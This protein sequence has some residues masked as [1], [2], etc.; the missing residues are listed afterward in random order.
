MQIWFLEKGSGFIEEEITGF[1]DRDGICHSAGDV[2]TSAFHLVI[3][4]NSSQ[5]S[6][7][8]VGS[9]GLHRDFSR[10]TQSDESGGVVELIKSVRSDD[11]RCGS[12]ESLAQCAHSAKVHD[13]GASREKLREGNAAEVSDTVRKIGQLIGESG[14]HKTTKPGCSAPSNRFDKESRFGRYCGS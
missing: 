5:L 4:D 11:L 9:V 2:T 10:H 13:G 14:Q 1:S 3:R 6:G 12:F 8:V 7:D